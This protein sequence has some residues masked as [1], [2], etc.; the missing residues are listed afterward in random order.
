MKPSFTAHAAADGAHDKVFN[1]VTPAKRWAK[2]RAPA[3][4]EE[5]PE[6][7]K[8]DLTAPLQPQDMKVAA[9]KT[10]TNE[11]GWDWGRQLSDWGY[12]PQ[13]A[14]ASGMMGDPQWYYRMLPYLQQQGA[15]FSGGHL[16]ALQARNEGLRQMLEN[17][18]MGA[19]EG[20]APGL[21]KWL[22][23]IKGGT[24]ATI[25][26][27]AQMDPGQTEGRGYQAM[28]ERM[29]DAV[30][31]SN[32]ELSDDQAIQIAQQNL[33]S[34][35]EFMGELGS[36]LVSE[37]APGPNLE[38]LSPWL[39]SA[40]GAG[41]GMR[42]LA[43]PQS[44]TGRALYYSMNPPTTPEEIRESEM[45]NAALEGAQRSK[46]LES[47]Q[48][49]A[50]PLMA[51]LWALKG[52][53]ESTLGFGGSGIDEG[54]VD[55]QRALKALRTGG[56][57]ANQVLLE[58]LQR[59]REQMQRRRETENSGSTGQVGMRSEAQINRLAE[60]AQDRRSQGARFG[61]P[62]AETGLYED[63]FVKAE[64]MRKNP[65]MNLGTLDIG[66][67]DVPLVGTMTGEES[68]AASRKWSPSE[69]GSM[70][71]DMITGR[72]STHDYM[73][74]ADP[75]FGKDR[76]QGYQ[77]ATK[78]IES[79]NWDPRTQ[80]LQRSGVRIA[81]PGMEA[82]WYNPAS[83]FGWRS[84]GRTGVDPNQLKAQFEKS[85]GGSLRRGQASQR[86]VQQIGENLGEE[87]RKAVGWDKYQQEYTQ[88][89]PWGAQSMQFMKEGAA[90]LGR[91][92]QRREKLAAAEAPLVPPP[93][94][95]NEFYRQQILRRQ[96]LAR[97]Q[98]LPQFSDERRLTDPEETF[99]RGLYERTH[100]TGR[101]RH[102]RN[103]LPFLRGMMTDQ[104]L[105]YFDPYVQKQ[106]AEILAGRWRP[107]MALAPHA[108]KREFGWQNPLGGLGRFLGTVPG[109]G[110]EA[111]RLI[112]GMTSSPEYR[113]TMNLYHQG[114]IS[115][116]EL[117]KELG[118]LP[119][120][121]AKFRE[122]RMGFGDPRE[123]GARNRRL[124]ADINT[125]KTFEQAKDLNDTLEGSQAYSF[126]L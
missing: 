85:V 28:L 72:D 33:G 123:Q 108:R 82:P 36:K 62:N 89:R 116:D 12:D 100:F 6:R 46:E 97:R 66:L 24:G 25:T 52:L 37:G 102:A 63:P 117:R 57:S 124:R 119:T 59:Q 114:M 34:E 18:G 93:D 81:D 16:A 64:A 15:Q 2:K 4:A 96:E 125:K 35:R 19:R 106:K 39:L 43:L 79:G 76:F 109:Q 83:W 121:T 22:E 92:L 20:E 56:T 122:A 78:A 70:A 73:T 60:R 5:V 42:A 101:G 115:E 77:D 1:F 61:T 94:F 111:E 118:G 41:I 69:W 67:G 86:D 103:V 107:G 31:R 7:P 10:A 110:Q 55:M 68:A 54:R 47:A 99:G 113:K 112:Q 98:R 87:G 91:W 65:Y 48:R 38:S 21:R 32:P 45:V 95:L 17:V 51:P 3:A 53:E 49:G 74:R 80:S 44:L 71:K 8:Q 84:G 104:D 88:N 126:G 58:Q 9:V 120:T 14:Q 11:P 40:G 26:N 30:Q 50:S 75:T 27:A 105:T 90:P 23:A 13:E 29:A